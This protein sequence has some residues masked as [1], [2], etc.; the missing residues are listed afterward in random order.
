MTLE[1]KNLVRL[2]KPCRFAGSV[3]SVLSD[4]TNVLHTMVKRKIQPSAVLNRLVLF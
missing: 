1:K 2:L 4:D 3:R